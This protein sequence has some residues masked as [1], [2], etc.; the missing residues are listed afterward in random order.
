MVEIKEGKIIE[1]SI[2]L[3][4]GEKKIR[5]WQKGKKLGKGGFA[6]VYEFTN[7]DN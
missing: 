3:P 2:D 5:K 7:L 4:N 1:E 6:S